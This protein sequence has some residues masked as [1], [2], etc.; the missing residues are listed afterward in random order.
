[1]PGFTLTAES[2]AKLR[3]LIREEHAKLRNPDGGHRRLYMKRGD[4]GTKVLLS[5]T[6]TAWT[7]GTSRTLNHYTGTQGSETDSG[8]E[9]GSVYLRLADVPS[10]HWV[11]VAHVA[12]RLEV[13]AADPC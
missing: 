5:K 9:I 4:K 13:I 3:A 10:G 8:K 7:K 11:Y 6:A 1:M 12:G 2:I